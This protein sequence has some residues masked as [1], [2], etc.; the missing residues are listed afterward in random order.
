MLSK[1]RESAG[2]WII[3]ILLGIII[4]AFVFMYAGGGFDGGRITKAASVNGEPI[5]IR[6]Y[7]QTYKSIIDRLRQQFGDRLDNDMLEMFN[8]KRQAINQVIEAELLRQTAEKYNLQVTPA[9][10]AET[11]TSIPAFQRNGSFNQRQYKMVLNQNRLSP[12][13]FEALQ[14][15]SM[16]I[17]KLRAVVASGIQVSPA[18]AQEW[19]NW[20][21]S[22]IK[23]DYAVFEPKA[24]SD[25]SINEDALKT[26]YDKHKEA[27][28]TQPKIKARY[29]KFSIEDY[30]PK[31]EIPEENIQAYYDNNQKKYQQPATVHARHILLKLA[32]DAR[33]EEVS[34]KRQKA[35]EIMEQAKAGEDFAE[36]AEQYSEGPSK[37]KGGDLGTFEKG[38]M[39]KPFSDKAFSMASGDIS[40]PVRTRFG[41]H[42]IKIEEK[43]EESVKPLAEVKDKIRKTLA[44]GEAKNL[45][46]DEAI[47]L[48]NTSFSGDDLIKNTRDRDDI[49]VQTT[50][51][52]TKTQGPASISKAKAFAEEA[53]KLPLMDVSDIKEL[54]DGFYLIQVIEKQE[55]QIPEFEAVREKVTRDW[56]RQEQKNA[57]KS[58]AAKFLE[59]VKS[60]NSIKEAGKNAAIEINTTDFFNRNQPIPDIGRDQAV[61]DA[62]FSLSD[63]EPFPEA[64]IDGRKGFYVIG[65]AEKQ[66]PEP[67]TFKK[68]KDNITKQ[69]IRQKQS[70]Y[71]DDWIA[72]LKEKSDIEITE[73][74]I[75]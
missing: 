11:I 55:A 38:D 44:R 3:K 17:Q 67:E 74:L 10:L 8:V 9:E 68:E 45:A 61:I 27:Y 21:N 2:S 30:L 56:K 41:W 49:S 31:I 32:E 36:L 16:L 52:F 13:A 46:Y 57:A 39:V 66:L 20:K 4:L 50:D 12:E 35:L 29:V 71:M 73:Q 62:A 5:S 63:A 7:Q 64:P 47:S 15:E 75:D 40:E 48:Y 24:F 18:E 26:Y 69:L 34:K 19:Y 59:T 33:P 72:Q 28:K 25:I 1:M 6:E 23:I 43:T 22:E 58:A 54:E 53:F 70:R 51:F 14:G 60:F 65:F 42:I 37:E